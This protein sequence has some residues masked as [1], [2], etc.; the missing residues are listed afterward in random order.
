MPCDETSR[1][2]ILT[3]FFCI[4]QPFNYCQRTLSIL[5]HVFSI[6]WILK[7]KPHFNYILAIICLMWYFLVFLHPREHYIS[8]GL[9]V[10]LMC[11]CTGDRLYYLDSLQLDGIC[12]TIFCLS[13]LL[14]FKYSLY[15]FFLIMSFLSFECL[16]FLF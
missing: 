9:P 2:T 12:N 10:P 16:Y 11:H 7:Y 6:S 8:G 1:S 15:L 14:P 13:P 5:T 4:I 3:T